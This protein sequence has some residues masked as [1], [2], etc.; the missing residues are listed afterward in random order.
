MLHNI[1]VLI[2]MSLLMDMNVKTVII[3]KKD[4]D[5]QTYMQRCVIV[6]NHLCCHAMDMWH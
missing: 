6:C 2:V 1:Y 5:I 3:Q 4:E